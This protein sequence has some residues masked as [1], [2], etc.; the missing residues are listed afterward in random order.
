MN[1]LASHWLRLAA[2]LFLVSPIVAALVA[3]SADADF[4]LALCVV[5]AA[6]ALGGLLV[7]IAAW[8]VRRI[9]DRR[10]THSSQRRT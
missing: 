9:R 4:M 1:P 10:A 7:R 6:I 5:L 2:W 8:F 3:V